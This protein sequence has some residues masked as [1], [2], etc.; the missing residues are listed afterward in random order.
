[1]IQPQQKMKRLVWRGWNLRGNVYK[2]TSYRIDVLQLVMELAI[3]R[4]VCGTFL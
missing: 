2:K 3:Y 1:M 4:R